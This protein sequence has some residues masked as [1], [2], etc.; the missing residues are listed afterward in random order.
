MVR[1]IR[2][3]TCTHSDT[4]NC[5]CDNSLMS[6]SPQ[7]GSTKMT[8]RFISQTEFCLFFFFQFQSTSVIS[9]SVTSKAKN[10]TLLKHKDIHVPTNR[11]PT[12]EPS[13]WTTLS[14]REAGLGTQYVFF[15]WVCVCASE[16]ISKVKFERS[17]NLS[18]IYI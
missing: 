1:T 9:I 4:P 3:D 12:L 15:F 5:H 11:I 8:K 10:L 17:L 16:I 14:P 18:C 7:A 6:R 2:A 13:Q